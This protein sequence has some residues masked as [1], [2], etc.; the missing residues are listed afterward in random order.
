MGMAAA[1]MIL[2]RCFDGRW[3]LLSRWRRRRWSRTPM[4][5]AI[6]QQWG[7]PYGRIGR[8]AGIQLTAS[9]LP[10][11]KKTCT[12]QTPITVIYCARHKYYTFS[13]IALGVL[14]NRRP[15]THPQRRDVASERARSTMVI[16]QIS[17]SCRCGDSYC[18]EFKNLSS[19]TLSNIGMK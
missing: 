1:F 10:N 4:T 13:G 8:A 12:A 11:K 9:R 5:Q 16:V 3:S 18:S 6:E 7:E 19:W 2:V 15:C 17:C 14:I